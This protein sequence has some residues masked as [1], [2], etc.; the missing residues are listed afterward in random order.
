M[1]T[2]F[3]LGK[4]MNKLLDFFVRAERKLYITA[5][6]MRLKNRSMTVLSSNCN[7]AYML[8]DL[9]CP[10]NSPTVN[11]Y[12][13]PDHFLKFVNSPKEYLSAELKEVHQP[14][15]TYP[16][17]Q[18]NDI[19]L[20][21]MHYNS[22]SEAKEVWERRAKRVNLENVYVIMTD[23]NGCTY[24]NIKE[25][26]E[27]PYKNKVIFTHKEYKEFSSA[28]YIPG[29]ENESEVGIL[30]DWKPQLLRRR[31]LDDFDSVGFFNEDRDHVK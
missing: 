27:L 29:F 23:K 5:K 31:W 16:V 17:G 12:F 30:S 21:F 28:Y 25:F 26:E 20:F 13:L 11:L 8:H 18:L 7:G 14:D 1:V 19:L 6:R 2:F 10:F 4:E 24:E 3:R 9:G 15:I 22:F